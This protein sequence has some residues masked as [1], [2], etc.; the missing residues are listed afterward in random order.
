[1]AK[2]ISPVSE[3]I[4]QAPAQAGQDTVVQT[5]GDN[6]ASPRK[7]P[8]LPIAAFFLAVGAWLALAYSTG[9]LAMAVAAAAIIVGA[10]GC[11]RRCSWRNLAITSIIASMVLIVVVA[12]FIIVLK[13]GLAA[14]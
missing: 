6:G 7:S 12:A 14:K 13:I 2:D 3:N 4:P 11:R 9:Y 1:M 8:W 10:F 5:A